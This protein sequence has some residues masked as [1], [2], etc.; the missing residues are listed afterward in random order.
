MTTGVLNEAYERL[1][2]AGPEWGEDT[3][4]NHGPMAVE[5]LVRHGYDGRVHRWLDDYIRRLDDMPSAST[6]I[7]GENWREALGDGRR[8]GDWTTYFVR[9][10]G[11]QPWR[12]LLATWW[13]RLLPGIVAGATH[14][15]IRV[16]HAVHALLTGPADPPAVTE[17]AHGLAFWAARW[18]PVPAATAAAGRLDAASALA[19]VPR[20]GDQNG[21][22]AARLGQ[23]PGLPGW[24]GALAGLRAPRTPDE[25]RAALRDLV[26]AGTLQYLAHG[27]ASPVLLVHVATAPNAVLRTLPALPTGRWESS[28]NAVWAASAAIVSAY[29]PAHPVDRAAHPAEPADPGE[30]FDAAV[31]HRDEHVIKFSD[32]A[33]EVF[34]WTGNRDALTAAVHITGLIG[35]P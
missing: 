6:A 28:L 10:A 11:E 24:T 21:P 25:V 5:T 20:I 34:A 29:A 18:R 19:A 22:V 30:V 33:L 23:L 9:E 31:R 35:S 13:P 26:A 3:L 27:H 12:D 2:F 8:I 17:L 7:T 4:T 14:G 16:G 1:H 32:T 15:A